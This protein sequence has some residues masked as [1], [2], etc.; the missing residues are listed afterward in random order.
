MQ[1]LNSKNFE[2]LLEELNACKEAKVWAQ[3]KS[4]KEVWATCERGDWMLWLLKIMLDKPGWINIRQLTLSKARCTKLIILLM[5]DKRSR[6]AVNIAEKFGLGNATR[7]E[8]NAASAAANAA[9]DAAY[10]AAYDDDAYADDAYADAA[11]SAANAAKKETLKKCADIIRTT[12]P[13]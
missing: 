1:D 13:F 9:A 11:A 8:L 2:I 12:I 5:K 3:D 7:K 6:N 10:D 4:L